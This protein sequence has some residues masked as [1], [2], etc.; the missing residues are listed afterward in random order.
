MST[1][2][3]DRLAPAQGSCIILPPNPNFMQNW[4]N[5]VLLRN[6]FYSW[7]HVFE[8]KEKH[9]SSPGGQKCH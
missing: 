2:R 9:C 5:R 6:P 7:G 4:F 3:E 1:S 8:E